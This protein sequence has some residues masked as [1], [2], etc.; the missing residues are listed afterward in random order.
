MASEAPGG[1]QAPKMADFPPLRNL[2]VPPKVQP[3]F[4]LPPAEAAASR[5]PAAI[6]QASRRAKPTVSP[7]PGVGLGA[8]RTVLEVW[9]A[10]PPARSV[11]HEK[12]YP[13]SVNS[14][15]PQL[16]KNKASGAGREGFPGLT[17]V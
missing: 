8:Y 14:A 3:R 4:S 5:E 15:S 12:R 2:K 7:K 17:F 10:D 13:R 9:E 1:A 6:V 11:K 16:V